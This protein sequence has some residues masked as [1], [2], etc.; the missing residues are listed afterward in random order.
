MEEI[1]TTDPMF[2]IGDKVN[3]IFSRNLL[4]GEATYDIIRTR[5]VLDLQ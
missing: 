4:L 5:T 1:S 3:V 2:I